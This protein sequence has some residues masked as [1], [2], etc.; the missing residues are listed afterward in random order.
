MKVTIKFLNMPLLNNHQRDAKK[1]SLLKDLNE[2]N[3][4][5]N[6]IVGFRVTNVELY[7]LKLE[8]IKKKRTL[9]GLI[10]SKLF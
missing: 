1:T 6:S 2:T 10:K 7:K 9:S 8:A 4:N 3:N 5:L